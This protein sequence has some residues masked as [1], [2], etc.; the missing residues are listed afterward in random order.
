MHEACS[1]VMIVSQSAKMTDFIRSTIPQNKFYPIIV[2]DNAAQA[3]RT[4]RRIPCDIVIIDTPLPDEFGTR[5][6]LDCSKNHAAA[7]I[8]KPELIERTVYKVEPY[9]VVTLSKMLHRSILYQTVM[10]LASSVKKRNRLLN[11]N[12]ELKEKLR[13]LKLLTKAKGLLIT[14]KGMTEEQAHR[15]IEREAMNN[16][17]KKSDA[18]KI[19]IEKFSEED[20]DA[21]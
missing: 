4:L 7:I 15:Y 17:L 10:L 19:I 18:V 12:E 8:V 13:E 1:S 2:E 6:A 21:Q 16:G 20:R 5:L 3:R 14:K 11:D 9:G